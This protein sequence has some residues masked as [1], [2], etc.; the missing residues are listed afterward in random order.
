ME[1]PSF[2]SQWRLSSY[3]TNR[4]S[5]HHRRRRRCFWLHTSKDIS[6][7]VVVVLPHSTHTRHTFIEIYDRPERGG[8]LKA[9]SQAETFSFVF[10]K[11][12]EENTLD[13]RERKKGCGD[14][15]LTARSSSFPPSHSPPLLRS[16]RCL[17]WCD[18]R[19]FFFFSIK[20]FHFVS[21]ATAFAPFP[22]CLLSRRARLMQS[23]KSE[24]TVAKKSRE[25]AT[26]AELLAL[27]TRP[28]SKARRL[29]PKAA[30][31]LRES[32]TLTPTPCLH[33][34]PTHT[35]IFS[36]FLLLFLL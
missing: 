13:E 7:M 31:N 28:P 1:G 9:G 12:E 14:S 10:I 36:L 2:G 24:R 30:K 4:K 3:H 20:V 17:C 18:V 32:T 8:C 25:K 11:E 6:K 19:Q 35:P 26:A 21:L 33:G 27:V 15:W 22:L 34:Q 29:G 16:T 5:P 23:E